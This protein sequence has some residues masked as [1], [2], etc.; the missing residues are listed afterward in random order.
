MALKQSGANV[1][2]SN[3]QAGAAMKAVDKNK[4]GKISK[5]ELY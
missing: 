4:D 3:D 2:V 5:D 1:S